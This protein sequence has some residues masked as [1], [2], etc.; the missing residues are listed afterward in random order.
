[1]TEL[2]SSMFDVIESPN[3]ERDYQASNLLGS[4]EI[5]NDHIVTDSWKI[6]DQG[7]TNKCTAFTL[8]GIE[9]IMNYVES[10]NDE[11]FSFDYSYCDSDVTD[12]KTGGRY[13]RYVLK[14][15]QKNGV[16]KLS[17]FNPQTNFAETRKQ[18]DRLPQ[19]VHDEA[20]QFK[21]KSYYRVSKRIKDEAKRVLQKFNTPLFA[22]IK[23]YKTILEANK[24]GGYIPEPKEDDE[25]LGGHAVPIIGYDGDYFIIPNSWGDDFGDE[26]FC[27]LKID[28]STIMEIWLPLDFA[29]TKIEL[30]IGK[31]DYQV[32]G[33]VKTMDV[34]P[35]VDS[36]TWRTVVPLRFVAEAFNLEVIPIFDQNG[37]TKE[38]RIKEYVNETRLSIGS[39]KAFNIHY[40]TE[41]ETDLAPFIKNDRTYIPLRFVS[42]VLGFNVAPVYY[43]NGS[44]R[45]VII[46]NY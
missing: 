6:L 2:K 8:V 1:M 7:S 5:K 34:E 14:K 16:C 30:D 37:L 46:Q 27:Y 28:S 31:K 44:T 11:D 45:S 25:L 10:G 38:V 19:S 42:E 3:D 13:S 36:K 23:V 4:E 33:A 24:N 40:L 20:K 21:L 17:S 22:S 32:N 26:G 41:Y 29:P 18:F 9:R 35:Y 12:L 43:D 15:W 39:K